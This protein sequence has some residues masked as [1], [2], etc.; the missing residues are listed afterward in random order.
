MIRNISR[1]WYVLAVA[2]MAVVMLVAAC[3]GDDDDKATIKFADNQFGGSLHVLTGIAKFVAENGYGHPTE[4]IEMTTPVY[5]VTLANGESHIMMEGWEQNLVDWYAKESAAGNVLNF[6]ESFEGGPQFFVIPQWVHDQHGINTVAD[7]M[8]KWELFK[9]PEDG[10][11]GV[12]YNCI[13]GWQC[14]EINNVK[15]Q[16]YGLDKQFNIVSPGSAG[17]LKA[18]LAGAQVKNEPVFGYYWSP[19]DLMSLYDWYILE[20]PVYDA[21]AWATISAAADDVS[22]RPVDQAVAYETVPIN[23]LVHKSLPEIAP[24]FSDFLRQMSAGLG[25]LQKTLGWLDTNEVEDH[26]GLG[27][28]HFMRNNTDL[29]K[30]WMDKDAWEDVE[31]ALAQQPATN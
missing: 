8:D 12:F 27:A 23:K 29:V 26:I 15:L 19:T 17:A 14:A 3:G 25:P 9:D 28:F 10:S 7:M 31:E 11:K 2:A 20:E 1:K 16:A 21:A 24:E 22:L 6:G 30:S 5:T 18:A 4:V 13:I